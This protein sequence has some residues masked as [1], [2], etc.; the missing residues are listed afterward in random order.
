MEPFRGPWYREDL[1]YTR[2]LAGGICPRTPGLPSP[3]GP[4]P[5]TFRRSLCSYI[6]GRI[7]LKPSGGVA[8]LAASRGFR[9]P[10]PRTCPW[11]SIV[12][13]IWNLDSAP[14]PLP[15]TPSN[16]AQEGRN[17]ALSAQSPPIITH[18]ARQRIDPQTG[19]Q[20]LGTASVA[21]RVSK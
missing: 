2:P 14:R 9:C 18:R 15:G 21:L 4:R 16:W 19:R 5:P 17:L 12:N 20:R 6:L 8:C 10:V 13:S 1:S 3:I 7:Y 11:R